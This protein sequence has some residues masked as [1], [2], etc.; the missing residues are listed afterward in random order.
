LAYPLA[1]V[2]ARPAW[3]DVL[4]GLFLPAIRADGAY[5]SLMLALIGTTITP[6]MQLFQQSAVVEN[7][8]PRRHYGP[9]RT[10]AYVGAAFSNLISAFIVIAA[11]AT[12]NVAGI[13]DVNTAQDA[14]RALEP[15]AGRGAQALFGVGL[16]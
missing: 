2:L 15:V 1:A 14:A 9:E 10:D 6:Y 4:H 16:L 13:T 5:F 7:G 3:G 11:G 12:L 8:V